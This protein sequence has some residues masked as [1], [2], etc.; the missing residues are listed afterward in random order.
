MDLGI[1]R[2]RH[3]YKAEVM[4]VWRSGPWYSWIWVAFAPHS[5]EWHGSIDEVS[6]YIKYCFSVPNI[7]RLLYVPVP[8]GLIAMLFL[9]NMIAED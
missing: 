4:P 3:F 7:P 6:P 2:P 1:T 9:D 8:L 5:H